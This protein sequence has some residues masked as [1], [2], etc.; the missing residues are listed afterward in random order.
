MILPMK[1]LFCVNANKYQD[2]SNFE[3]YWPASLDRPRN[4]AVMFVNE[5]N[6]YRL[7][8]LRDVK[9]CIIYYPVRCEVSDSIKVKN[10]LIETAAPRTSYC[11][12]FKENR[13][14]N[15]PKKEKCVER[16]G[17]QISEDARIGANSTIMP[18]AYIGGEVR[19]GSDC[20]I[21]TG[22][23]LVGRIDIGNRVVIR[24]NTV[25]GAD[26]LSTD[27]DDDGKAATMP[28]FGTVIIEDDV[29]IGANTVIARGAIDDTTIRRGAKIDNACFISHNVCIGE[30]TFIVGETIMFGGSTV[31]DKAFISGNST[32]R[33]KVRIENEA[34]IGMG[35]VV[36]KD[37]GKG[38]TVMGNPARKKGATK[39][40]DRILSQ[41]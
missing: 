38:V 40:N 4:N 1:R 16:N 18:F 17:A 2:G 15:L 3:V 24:E 33:N 9:E 5:E 26:G 32:V 37:I 29:Q 27:R 22:V 28:Q 10:V 25:I 14:S 31:G 12:F 21:G 6:I 11:L 35:S 30:D 19:I 13:I 41:L 36:T 7:D 39:K 34:M 23:R 8:R 20:Y